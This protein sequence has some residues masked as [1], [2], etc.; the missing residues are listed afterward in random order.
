M[1]TNSEPLNLAQ[2]WAVIRRRR[3]SMFVAAFLVWPIACTFAWLFPPRYRAQATILIEKPKVPKQY[4]TPNIESDPQQQMQTLT[5]QILSRSRLQ[6]I[7]DDLHLYQGT[8]FAGD[9]V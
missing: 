9:A 4:V 5:Q 2:Y 7:I 8:M 1:Q 6:G 3:R